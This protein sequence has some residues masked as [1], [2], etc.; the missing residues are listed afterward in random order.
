[1]SISATCRFSARIAWAAGLVLTL[2][3]ANGCKKPALTHGPVKVTDGAK[4][5]AVVVPETDLSAY[6][7][8]FEDLP[9][10]MGRDPFFPNSHR[11]EPVSVAVVAQNVRVDPVLVLKGIVGSSTHRLAVV[12][13][14]I[15]EVGEESPV[16]V[17]NGH[18]RVKCLEIGEDY[19]VVKVDGE[20]EPKRLTMDTKKN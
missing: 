5:N 20:A 11:R 18:I 19:V 15:L 9:P 7:S 16:R 12:N 3:V 13:N 14:E 1:M 17:P 8:V 2:A 6:A 10:K 4:T